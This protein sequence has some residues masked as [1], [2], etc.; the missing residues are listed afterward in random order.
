MKEEMVDE[1]SDIRRRDNLVRGR[2]LIII[3]DRGK[4]PWIRVG[5]LRCVSESSI[6]DL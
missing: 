3:I 4:C 2:G 1:L 5:A 6:R